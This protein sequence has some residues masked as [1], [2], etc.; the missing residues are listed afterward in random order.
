MVFQVG[1]VLES[2]VFIGQVFVMHLA[3]TV[4]GLCYN[5][6]IMR[7]VEHRLR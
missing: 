7:A 2:A 3:I 1:S 6:R 5:Y 4:T